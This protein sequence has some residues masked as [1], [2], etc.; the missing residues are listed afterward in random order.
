MLLW[1]RAVRAHERGISAFTLKLKY[2][3]MTRVFAIVVIEYSTHNDFFA[4]TGNPIT[5]TKFISYFIA[6]KVLAM[7]HPPPIQKSE[8]YGV[9]TF[10]GVKRRT[11]TL[12]LTE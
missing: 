5:V 12:M 1:N 11:N 9:A 10:P 3:Y 6:V 2:L 8:D 7:F 4:L